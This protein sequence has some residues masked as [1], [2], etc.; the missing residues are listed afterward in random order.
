MA[1]NFPTSLDNFTNPSSGNTLDSPSHSLQHSDINDAVEAL[2]AKL[3]I[4]VSPAGSATS[5]Q[6]LTAQGGGTALWTTP[7]AD[8][9]VLIDTEIFT[10]VTSVSVDNL[11]S[12]TYKNYRLVLTINTSS[13]TGDNL[14]LRFR[15]A[16][17]PADITAANYQYAW[18][19]SSFNNTQSDSG[20]TGQTSALNLSVSDI[21][22]VMDIHNPFEAIVTTFNFNSSSSA[23]S[24][25]GSGQY[26]A[27]T[28]AGGLTILTAGTSNLTGVLSVYGYKE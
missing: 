15:T 28:S 2:E 9:L 6:V 17:S 7:S 24:F 3:G 13:V 21:K 20:A 25:V 10:T 8:G 4:G 5:G 26:N 11:F 1:S 14:L 19:V 22:M 18:H 23:S 12:S 16:T 27:T